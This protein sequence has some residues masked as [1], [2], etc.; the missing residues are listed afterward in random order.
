MLRTAMRC[1]LVVSCCVI[2]VVVAGCSKNDPRVV[3]VNIPPETTL[4]F[5]PDPGDTV[6]YR[7][8]M[9][10]FGWDPDGEVTHFLTRWDSLGWRQTTETDTIFTVSTGDSLDDDNHSFGYHVFEVKAVDNSGDE[11]PTPAGVSFTAENVLPETELTSI[12]DYSDLP[13]ATFEWLGSDTDGYIAGYGYRLLIWDEVEYVVY[14]SEDDLPATQRIA[15]FGPLCGSFRF[16]VWSIDDQ[17]DVDPTPAEWSFISW[18]TPEPFVITT[19]VF[20]G[21]RRLWHEFPLAYDYDPWQIFHGENLEFAWGAEGQE[22]E[23]RHAYD[24]TA[25]WSTWSADD[26][27]FEVAPESGV[28]EMHVAFR[29][30]GGLAFHMHLRF[31]AVEAG[32][33]DYVLIVDDYDKWESNPYWGFDSE[34]DAFYDAI[35]EPF[36]SRHQWDPYEH[37]VAGVPTPPDFETLADASTVVWYCDD[38]DAVIRQ[39]FDGYITGYDLLGGYVRGGGN[40][41]L[42]GWKTLRQVADTNYPFDLGPSDEELGKRFV[43]DA[44]RI[45]RVDNSGEGANPDYPWD[46]GYCM[47]GALPTVDGEA[48]GFEPA[49]IDTGQCPDE[50]GKWFSFCQPPAPQ[51]ERC[52]MNVES[53]VP[54]GASSLEIL[55]VDSFNN[56]AWDGEPCAVLYLS[57]SDRGNVC[58]MGFPVYYLQTA[59]A[60]QL[61]R[62]VLTLFGEEER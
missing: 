22:L 36:G 44:L 56:P 32:M 23:F 29:D 6:G 53:V 26:T 20:N 40:L 21:Y 62:R 52:G 30:T 1:A 58:Y 9:R 2:A 42:S 39:L 61:M 16:E 49:Y 31:D 14:Q 10:W 8:E 19:N 25:N 18:C 34:R 37:L 4:S 43:R 7:V 3:I 41:I 12:L 15:D 33:D 24:D 54:Y 57:G 46:Y 51:Y 27:H 55:E 17:G 59:H 28:H 38:A 5:A 48:L 50:P 13:Y 47:H 11:D 45:G 60:E 35:V